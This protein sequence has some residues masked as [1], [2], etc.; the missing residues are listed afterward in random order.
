MPLLLFSPFTVWLRLAT[1]LHN[2][3]LDTG[4]K[5]PGYRS[6]SPTFSTATTMMI[7]VEHFVQGEGLEP[8][9]KGMVVLLVFK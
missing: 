8:R 7:E 2:T 6:F 3:L 1:T 4:A 9:G 5:Q